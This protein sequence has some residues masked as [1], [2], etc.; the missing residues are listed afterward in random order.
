[1]FSQFTHS[2]QTYWGRYAPIQFILTF[3][4]HQILRTLECILINKYKTEGVTPP[5]RY[6]FHI[7][8]QPQCPCSTHLLHHSTLPVPLYYTTMPSLYSFTTPQ[9]P[10]STTLLHH[11]ALLVAL[12]Y[13]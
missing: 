9:Y 11:C 6:V 1:M 8:S 13:V 2:V 10:L 7:S 3:I 12:N 4:T 5:K